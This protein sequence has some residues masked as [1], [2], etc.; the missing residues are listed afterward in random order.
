MLD[1]GLMAGL[2]LLLVGF[3]KERTEGT[4]FRANS[5]AP[6]V[7]GVKKEE[8]GDGKGDTLAASWRATDRRR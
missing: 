6:G 7:G 8:D 5:W 1:L 4:G 3:L 2:V